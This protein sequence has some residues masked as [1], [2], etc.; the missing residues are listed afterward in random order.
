LA[1]PN[2]PTH[3]TRATRDRGTYGLSDNFINRGMNWPANLGMCP[4]H[5]LVRHEK[6]RA[7]A[8]WLDWNVLEQPPFCSYG[9]PQF[10]DDD[11]RPIWRNE[12]LQ[13]SFPSRIIV[14]TPSNHHESS[15]SMVRLGRKIFVSWLVLKTAV[16][17]RAG[18]LEFLALVQRFAAASSP[19]RKMLE[20]LRQLTRLAEPL[21]RDAFH[22][23]G[24]PAAAD[25]S[26]RWPP[27]PTHVKESVVNLSRSV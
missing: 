13:S 17:V 23:P 15:C 9:I 11:L 16:T 21:V 5:W 10:V 26:L 2:Q 20:D 8:G 3:F 7:L 12:G 1:I 19:M 25:S 6:M 4:P 18:S 14:L 24:Q 22:G 27:T